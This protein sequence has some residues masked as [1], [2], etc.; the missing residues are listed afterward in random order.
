MSG[1]RFWRV[2]VLL[3]LLLAGPGCTYRISPPTALEDPVEV[4]VARHGRTSSLVLPGEDGHAAYSY[5]DWRWYAESRTN[6]CTGLAALLVPTRAAL[7][8]REIEGELSARPRPGALNADEVLTVRVE[9]F[10]AERLRSRLDAR[11]AEMEGELHENPVRNAGFVPAE[12]SYW[13]GNQSSSV[14]AGWLRELGC[15]V[16]G[17]ALLARFRL[18]DSG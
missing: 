14:V 1:V 8:R 7:G 15:E 5:G 13:L 18:R 6:P 2:V 3:L 9:R 4:H 17:W 10:E 16:R 11:F 12:S